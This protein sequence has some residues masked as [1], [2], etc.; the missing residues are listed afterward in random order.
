MVLA[1]KA[2]PV[3]YAAT[4]QRA[5]PDAQRK[6]TALAGAM[7][8]LSL[9]MS[10]VEK[11]VLRW[12][13]GLRLESERPPL[14]VPLWCVRTAQLVMETV[15]LCRVG[16]HGCWRGWQKGVPRRIW[17]RAR[18][19]KQLH[20]GAFEL[21]H[22]QRPPTEGAAPILHNLAAPSQPANSMHVTNSSTA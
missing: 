9:Q 14:N 19:S 1:A 3:C 4:G 8:G 21:Q 17:N 5:S 13:P 22:A 15:P 10:I 2:H 18:R 6:A 12:A 16:G 11:V 20:V 7:L